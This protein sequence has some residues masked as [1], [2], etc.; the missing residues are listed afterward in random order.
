MKKQNDNFIMLPT[1]DFC[2]KELMQNPKVRKGFIAALL[3]VSPESIS[4]TT[5][6]P[7]IMERRYGEDKMGIL[8]VRILMENGTQLGLEVQVAEFEYWD[9]R[10]LYYI[11]RQF[12]D[13]LKKGNGYDL[14]K[15]CIHVSILDY[16]RFPDDDR[17]YRT[18][19]IR[20]DKTGEIYSDLMEFHFLELKKV[21]RDVCTGEEIIAWMK[22][23]S[24]KR[25]EEFEVM[26]KT[27]EYLD[28]A[29]DTLVNLSADEKKRLVY[30]A[31]EKALKDYNTQMKSAKSQ[32]IR[33]GEERGIQIGEE[34][35]IQ[36][37]EERGIRIGEQRIKQVFRLHNQNK[38]P[39]EI[40]EICQIP[41]EKVLEILE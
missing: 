31:R 17:C 18:F 25:K 12:S 4:E 11:S 23:L 16:I 29:Y 38:T 9:E 28:E 5:L 14:L 24:G 20:D 7:T 22:F 27:N 2:F 13:Q 34:R 10:I 21:P 15:K 3:K 35:G 30:E 40:A 19:H 32:G 1:V 39:E 37:G 6:L 36:I 8:D 26:A 33:I 41:L